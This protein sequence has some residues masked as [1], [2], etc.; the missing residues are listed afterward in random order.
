MLQ[1][2]LCMGSFWYTGACTVLAYMFLSDLSALLFYINVICVLKL[3]VKSITKK[4]VYTFIQTENTHNPTVR[5][6]VSYSSTALSLFSFFCCTF[7]H[8]F[9]VLPFRP[10]SHSPS[11]P[12]L[13]LCIPYR[14]TPWSCMHSVSVAQC[15]D[16]LVE[17]TFFHQ[18][19]TES[20]RF[21]PLSV[22]ANISR[23][24]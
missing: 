7:F 21:T 24:S 12:T 20:S 9:I 2:V 15:L 13:I 14:E 11:C 16:L 23:Q 5:A 3:N 6:V 18:C 10:A 4:P 19:D 17:E 8:S 1:K 22:F